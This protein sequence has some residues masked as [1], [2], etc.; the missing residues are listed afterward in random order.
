MAN[1][2]EYAVSVTPVRTIA[3]AT[4]KYA[5]QDVMEADI[6]KTLGASDSVPT[7][8]TDISVTGFTAGAVEYGNCPAS[9]KLEVAG[10]VNAALDMLFIKH[11]GY[12]WGGNA[13]TLGSASASD[14]NLKVYVEH[15]AGAFTQVCS[16]APGGAIALPEVPALGSD[17]S[18][19]VESSGSESIAVEFAAIT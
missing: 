11:T 4:G 12:Q 2:V 1:R 3:G 9:G 6:N 17:L 19:H 14:S 13:T 8:A 16:I 10:T 5:E 7:G 18:F 15:S